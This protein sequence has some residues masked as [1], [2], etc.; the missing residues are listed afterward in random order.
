MKESGL[1][2][3]L[4][5]LLADVYFF[6]HAEVD[7]TSTSSGTAN[8]RTWTSMATESSKFIYFFK[9]YT[10]TLVSSVRYESSLSKLHCMWCPFLC[11]MYILGEPPCPRSTEQMV[12][13]SRRQTRA[14]C[15]FIRLIVVNWKW[16][17]FFA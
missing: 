9:S 16:A 7:C 14:G 11:I 2:M 1:C 8:T 12:T 3:P 15:S 13:S 4:A 17:D 6:L 10:H 5:Q